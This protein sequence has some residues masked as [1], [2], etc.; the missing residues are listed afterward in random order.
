MAGMNP[1]GSAIPYLTLSRLSVDES[2]ADF[3]KP[4]LNEKFIEGFADFD[5]HLDDIRMDWRNE[6]FFRSDA[7]DKVK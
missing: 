4:F 7:V 5:N 3:V 1:H 6:N 2:S